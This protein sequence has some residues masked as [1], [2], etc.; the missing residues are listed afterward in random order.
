MRLLTHVWGRSWSQTSAISLLLRYVSGSLFCGCVG[1]RLRGLWVKP[2]AP[3]IGLLVPVVEDKIVSVDT[4]VSKCRIQLPGIL[5]HFLGSVA[6][7]ARKICIRPSVPRQSAHPKGGRDDL[8]VSPYGVDSR[9]AILAA[10]VSLST[11]ETSRLLAP[12][13]KVNEFLALPMLL[14][15]FANKMSALYCAAQTSELD[16]ML[17]QH[18]AM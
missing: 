17:S 13:S 14:R 2:L 7:R 5:H 11:S 1:D 18:T 4:D 10:A 3:Y 9:L 12:E 15:P 16:R 8:R 6:A